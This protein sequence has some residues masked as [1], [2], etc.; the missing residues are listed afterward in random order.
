M[1][2]TTSRLQAD[3]LTCSLCSQP[4]RQ[5]KTL[6]CL[7]NFCKA[8]LSQYLEEE[9]KGGR[10]STFLCPE[11]KEKIYVPDPSKPANRWA[12]QFPTNFT[13]SGMVEAIAE[14]AEAKGRGI[15]MVKEARER[16]GLVPDTADSSSPVPTRKQREGSKE[17]EMT[18]ENSQ[19]S[20]VSPDVETTLA[21]LEKLQTELMKEN[22]RMDAH[23]LAIDTCEAEEKRRL[24]Q[25]FA[26]IY[27]LLEARKS[28]LLEELSTN[29]AQEKGRLQQMG[30]GFSNDMESV[31]SCMDLL[32]G[33]ESNPVGD[34]VVYDMLLAIGD[35]VK[36]IKARQA[37]LVPTRSIR[38]E[39]TLEAARSVLNLVNDL[40]Q[41]SISTSSL[42]SPVSEADGDGDN[43]RMA[44]QR[45]YDSDDDKVQTKIRSKPK[46]LT[47][48]STR[49]PDGTVQQVYDLAVTANGVIVMTSY[50]SNVVQAAQ[51]S[52]T[53]SYSIF[54][55]LTLDS[56]PKC[57]AAIAAF[58]VAVTGTSCI[59]ILSIDQ[60]LSLHRKIDTGKNYQGIA[61]YSESSLIVTSQRPACIDFIGLNGF[62][63]ETVDRDHTTGQILLR[64]PQF[65][66]TSKNGVIFVTDLGKTPRLISVNNA[67][68]VNFECSADQGKSEE[69]SDTQVS[70]KV[71]QG[72]CV[73]SQGHVFVVD[74]AAHKVVLLTSEGVKVKDIL[75]AEEGLT[76]PC[77]IAVDNEDHIYV[78]NEF[79][80][81]LIFQVR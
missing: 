27:M 67:G 44:Q 77:A 52:D 76:D 42:D 65:M 20:T 45:S 37:S 59:Y 50:G 36:E 18:K 56:E 31:V 38:F 34:D 41:I 62:I 10:A 22:Q 1:S 68:K 51:K 12:T 23:I 32:N 70:L 69:G 54:T 19:D 26:K 16:R 71:P 58:Y 25:S 6:P 61:T 75:T 40:G 33:L 74:R 48:V 9:M 29:L 5:P 13:L 21:R 28:Q 55:R 46:F 4:F 53:G 80:E 35:Q 2:D 17:K 79:N 14:E 7:H 49:Q 81:V 39:Q 43:K 3:Y 73:D 8:C 78:T 24:E 47:A 60:K 72:V 30:Q 63:S 11:C 57:V 66:A 15:A 64:Q